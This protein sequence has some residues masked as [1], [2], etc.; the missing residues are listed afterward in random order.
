MPNHWHMVVRP[1][2]DG[3]MGRFAQWVG[4]THTQRYHVHYQTTG[5][6]HVYQGRY[7]SFPVQCDGH[8]LTVCRYVERNAY[9]AK[10]CR[11][12][13]QW[14]W[15]SQYHWRKGDALSRQLI[16]TWPVR[17]RNNWIQWT[18]TD[19][20]KEERTKLDWSRDRGVPFGD[21]TWVEATARRFDLESTMRPRGRPNKHK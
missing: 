1:N 8:F 7:K 5:L 10:L 15:G 6:G 3:E 19:F 18:R 13:D 20:S 2:I 4:L 9:A 21:E 14:K 17:R 16:S 12:P 11:G